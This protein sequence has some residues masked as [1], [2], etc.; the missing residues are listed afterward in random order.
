MKAGLNMSSVMLLQ[1]EKLVVDEF[2]EKVAAASRK[3]RSPPNIAFRCL[4]A[5]LCNLPLAAMT[6]PF[7][8]LLLP[9]VLGP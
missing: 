1:N 7:H 5:A 9:F 8:A 2:L 3:V 4:L 6:L